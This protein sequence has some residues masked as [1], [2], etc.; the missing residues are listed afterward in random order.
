M[1]S[2]TR[3]NIFLPWVCFT[4]LA[5][6][7]EHICLPRESQRINPSLKKDVNEIIISMLPRNSEIFF[8]IKLIPG[9]KTLLLLLLLLLLNRY[10]INIQETTYNYLDGFVQIKKIK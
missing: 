9:N 5:S 4:L 10:K 7:V 2:V 6:I 3:G 8:F 1:S